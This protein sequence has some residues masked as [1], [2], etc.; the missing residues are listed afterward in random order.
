MPSKRFRITHVTVPISQTIVKRI[1]YS[2][3]WSKSGY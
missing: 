3:Y 2:K 1:Q